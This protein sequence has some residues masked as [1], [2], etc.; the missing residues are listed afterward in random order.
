MNN[1]EGTGTNNNNASASTTLTKIFE[2]IFN[3]KDLDLTRYTED[4]S[5][6]GEWYEGEFFFMKDSVISLIFIGKLLSMILI[7]PD[8]KKLYI[9]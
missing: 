3:A 5:H 2:E 1:A 8:L 6:T 4:E 9:K 7:K